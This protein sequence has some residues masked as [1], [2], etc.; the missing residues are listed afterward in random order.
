MQS[1]ILSVKETRLYEYEY[2]C[3]RVKVVK[4]CLRN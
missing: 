3:N 4:T 2:D 1:D